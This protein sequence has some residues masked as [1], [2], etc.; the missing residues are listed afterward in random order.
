MQAPIILYV[1]EQDGELFAG[2]EEEIA[3]FGVEPGQAM[4]ASEGN[5]KRH[6]VHL[7]E[8]LT[9]AMQ[10]QV[11]R[12][13]KVADPTGG[14]L[15]DETLRP[16]AMVEAYV[17]HWTFAHVLPTSEGFTHLHP[18]IAASLYTHL[19]PRIY[20]GMRG[21][22]GLFLHHIRVQAAAAMD[23]IRGTGLAQAYLTWDEL[24]PGVQ[25]FLHEELGWPPFYP[26]LTQMHPEDALVYLTLRRSANTGSAQANATS[27]DV[28]AHH[29][30]LMKKLTPRL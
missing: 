3:A 20:P 21:G 5:L 19:R 25:A 4:A 2:S 15:E 28:A 23:I 8:P 11:E 1:F 6:E 12:S 22:E 9:Y 14:V 17:H 18:A 16:Q 30:R 24:H 10:L 7:H 29:E 26:C 27:A 13:V